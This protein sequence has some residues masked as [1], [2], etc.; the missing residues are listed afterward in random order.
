M[1]VVSVRTTCSRN[2]AVIYRLR[3]FVIAASTFTSLEVSRAIHILI[4]NDQ[5]EYSYV[6]RI[7]SS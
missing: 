4:V 5:E 6:S 1:G 3:G 2:E 7:S